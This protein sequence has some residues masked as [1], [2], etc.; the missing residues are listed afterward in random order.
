[1]GE[2]CEGLVGGATGGGCAARAG[3]ASIPIS[4]T[5][6]RSTAAEALV[7]GIEPRFLSSEG[8]RPG[9]A[10]AGAG[11]DA[12]RTTQTKKWPAQ[13]CRCGGGRGAALSGAPVRARRRPAPQFRR[14]LIQR[15]GIKIKSLC[16]RGKGG[17]G[18]GSARART[19]GCA[20]NRCATHQ[21]GDPSPS[22]IVHSI[23]NQWETCGARGAR[24]GA[25]RD[26]HL[27]S[28]AGER[29]SA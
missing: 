10:G 29:G 26:A 21:V 5:D 11:S 6:E 15:F 16:E 17:R 7:M 18:E 24:G 12:R 9:R 28:G 4:N 8:A 19:A 20:A 14:S 13:M 22:E 2:S 1:M 23:R 25:S 27:P 3:R